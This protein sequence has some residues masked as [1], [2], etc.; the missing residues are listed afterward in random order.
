MTSGFE[1]PTAVNG[2]G[3]H[4]ESV[5]QLRAVYLMVL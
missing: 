3:G 1:D 5:P 4:R 2:T